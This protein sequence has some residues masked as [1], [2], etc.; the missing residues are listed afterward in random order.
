MTKL[1]YPLCGPQ[2]CL[3]RAACGARAACL[4]CLVYTVRFE[5]HCALIKDVGSDVHEH[6]YSK[7]RIKQLHTVPELHL[8]HCLTTEYSETTAHFN[9]NFDPDNQIYVL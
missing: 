5:S 8:S 9:G 7:N 4:T 1:Q 2:V 6:L 3:Q